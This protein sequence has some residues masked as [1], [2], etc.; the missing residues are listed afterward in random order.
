MT[1]QPV[2]QRTWTTTLVATVTNAGLKLMDNAR[3]LQEKGWKMWYNFLS[4]RTAPSVGRDWAFL[5]Y[6]F[7]YA[8]EKDRL[9]PANTD[10]EKDRCSM[11]LYY[12]CARPDK[13]QW[14]GKDVLEVG[15]GRGGGGSF[16]TRKL[17]PKSYVALD[18]AEEQIKTCK[19]IHAE[20]KDLSFVCGN[21]M[22]LPFEDAKF[23]IVMNVESSHVYSDFSKFVNEVHRVL[24]P[25]GSFCW[26]DFRAIHKL[27]DIKAK[28]EA[29]GFAEEWE[30]I[31]DGV[32]RGL[33]VSSAERETLINHLFQWKL[34]VLRSIG[35]Y[36]RGLVHNFAGSPGSEVYKKFSER[37]WEYKAAVFRKKA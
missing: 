30:D 28:L 14:P 15:S 20:V 26:T 16:L 3:G 33:D 13:V 1:S 6:A 5:N 25:G 17:K 7:E 37:Q 21:A 23:D 8:E 18:Y 31:T 34:P 24:K 12:N 22:E 11:Q 9:K 32:V 2:A 10:E 35:Q 36:L 4:S 29:A 19:R 27:P